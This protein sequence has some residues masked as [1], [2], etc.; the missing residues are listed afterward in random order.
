[1]FEDLSMFMEIVFTTQYSARF[2]FYAV[3]FDLFQPKQNGFKNK[4]KNPD[5]LVLKYYYQKQWA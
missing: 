1:M 5:R 3:L 2:F 4:R